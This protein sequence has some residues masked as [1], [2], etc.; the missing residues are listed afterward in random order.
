MGNTHPW[1]RLRRL[2]LGVDGSKLAPGHFALLRRDETAEPDFGHRV[3][4]IES[5]W[6]S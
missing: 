3:I 5:H 2:P 1:P 6:L 4:T